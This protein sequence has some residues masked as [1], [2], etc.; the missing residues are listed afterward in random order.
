MKCELLGWLSKKLF[1][2][3]PNY[4]SFN[5]IVL[6][7]MPI[8]RESLDYFFSYRNNH[9]NQKI[10]Y[11][12][13]FFSISPIIRRTIIIVVSGKY[14]CCDESIIAATTTIAVTTI[15][16]VTWIIVVHDFVSQKTRHHCIS[17]PGGNP[18]TTKYVGRLLLKRT[19]LGPPH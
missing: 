7:M 3:W 6:W 11:F 1:T 8:S 16:V 17:T 14:D 9:L 10:E 18:S 5:F 15:I 13:Y 2:E 4:F 12:D 19:F